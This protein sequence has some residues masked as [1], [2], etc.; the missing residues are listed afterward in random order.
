MSKPIIQIKELRIENLSADQ[1]F[2]K[3][4]EIV[5]A[6]IQATL[7][8]KGQPDHKSL[9]QLAAA[10]PVCVGTL[11]NYIKSGRLKAFKIGDR[12]FVK[13]EDFEKAMSE[14]KSKKYKR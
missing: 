2:S 12:V 11:R 7:N 6:K 1:L 4:E 14:V 5:D 8:K 10:N 3:I 9:Q 13:N